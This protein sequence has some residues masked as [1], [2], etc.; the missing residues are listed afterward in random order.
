MTTFHRMP[1]DD[2][3]LV[4]GKGAP[5]VILDPAVTSYGDIATARAIA[6]ELA[7][8]GYRVLA[9]ADRVLP[10]GARRTEDG[11]QLVGLVALTDPVRHNAADG[12]DRLRP[13][14]SRPAADHRRRTRHG[15]CGGRARRPARGSR[16]HRRRHRRRRRPATP[17]RVFARIRPEQKLDIV[18]AWQHAGQVV[19][20]TGDGVNDAPA[21]RRADIGV[22][23]GKAVPRWPGRRP[24]WS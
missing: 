24:T 14:R 13:S 23:M 21:L 22:A 10:P 6:A 7:A 5:E 18:R 20:M 19:A 16:H 2:G 9:V 4:V 3:T 12:D 1:G 15:T 11:L 17:G 8:D